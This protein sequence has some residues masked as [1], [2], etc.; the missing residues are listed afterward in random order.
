MADDPVGEVLR[1]LREL[2]GEMATRADLADLRGEMRGGL[3]AL[4]AEVGTVRA[5]LAKLTC[6]V[7]ILGRE[8]R[9]K[10]AELEHELHELPAAVAEAVK[11]AIGPELRDLRAD[12]DEL[13]EAG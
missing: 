10:W 13:K 3:E 7:E 2:R 5:D 8:T 9:R 11:Q 12:V 1:E 6:D 4:R